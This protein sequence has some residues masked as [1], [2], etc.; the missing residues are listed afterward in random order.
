MGPALV[1]PAGYPAGPAPHPTSTSHRKLLFCY[2]KSQGL[3]EPERLLSE[4]MFEHQLFTRMA[5]EARHSL[6]PVSLGDA[7]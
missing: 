2:C 1:D 4:T 7:D 5:G 6:A 3:P